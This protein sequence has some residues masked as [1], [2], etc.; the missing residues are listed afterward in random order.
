MSRSP[1]QFR[2]LLG[3]V[4]TLA[5]APPAVG[6]DAGGPCGDRVLVVST[7]PAGCSTDPARLE[8]SVT[9]EERVAGSWSP[10]PLDAALGSL[11]PTLPVVIYVHGNQIAASDAKRT[12]LDVYRRLRRCGEGCGPMQFVVF[13]WCSDK[14]PGLLRD[15]REKAA[16]TRPVAWQFAWALARLPAGSRVGVIGYS[17][18]ARV[19]SGA[20]HLL[21]GG[22][23]GGLHCPS[24]GAGVAAMRGVFLAAAYDACWNSP[25][26]YHGR[27]LDRIDTLLTTVNPRDPAMKYFKWVP[28]DADPLALGAVG[29]RGLDAD[30]ASRVRAYPVAASVGRSHDLDDYLAAPGLMREAWRRLSFADLAPTAVAATTIP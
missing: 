18:G 30:R 16:R 15:P 13:S 29:P 19:A 12:G 4:G 5:L 2:A 7:R 10:L 17:Y 26:G 28:R 1:L 24:D 25:R 20:A 9:A 21:A 8:A 14:V 27:A 22:T 3:L 23:L 11:D 6:S